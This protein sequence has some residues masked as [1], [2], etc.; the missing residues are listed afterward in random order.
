[1][2]NMQRSPVKL[3]L[4]METENIQAGSIK[5]P[6]PA[7]ALAI[8]LS[9]GGGNVGAAVT[10]QADLVKKLKTDKAVKTEIH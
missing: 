6:I 10:A 4:P 1:M 7:T 9:A 3:D 5:Q 2:P 8:E